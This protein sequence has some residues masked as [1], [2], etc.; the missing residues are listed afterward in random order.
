MKRKV[1]RLFRLALTG[2]TLICGLVWAETSD[3]KPPGKI[4]MTKIQVV[5]GTQILIATLDDTP[6]ARDFATLLPMNLMLRDYHSTEKIAD[7][8]RRLDT[9]DAPASYAPEVGDI[10]YYAPWGNL[11]IFYKP[12]Q[13]SAGLIRLGRLDGPTDALLEHAATQVHIKFAEFKNTP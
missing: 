1:A 6:A 9:K 10:T 12:F 4:T 2:M 11:A 8:P 13:N 3:K 5:V 7:L